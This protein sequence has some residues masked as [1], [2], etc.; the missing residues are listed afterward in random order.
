MMIHSVKGQP[1][2][3]FCGVGYHTNTIFDLYSRTARRMFELMDSNMEHHQDGQI[4]PGLMTSSYHRRNQ[5]EAKLKWLENEAR[6]ATRRIALHSSRDLIC[7]LKV[8]HSTNDETV[9]LRQLILTRQGPNEPTVSYI[10]RWLNM[11]PKCENNPPQN[12][13]IA[14]CLHSLHHDLRILTI[15]E[16]FENFEEMS[17]FM[18]T[19]EDHVLCPLRSLTRRT[20]AVNVASPMR[21]PDSKSDSKGTNVVFINPPPVEGYEPPLHPYFG[22]RTNIQNRMSNFCGAYQ[23]TMEA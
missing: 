8:C 2:R 16:N 7:I 5:Q 11:A 9:T 23:G 12:L 1:P 19:I 22:V 14:L 17:M 21:D 18:E 6:N 4:Y 10:N 15:G 20:H 13:W 3:Y